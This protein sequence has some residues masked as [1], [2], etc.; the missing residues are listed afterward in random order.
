[1]TALAY[2]DALELLGYLPST[3][4]PIEILGHEDSV[5]GRRAYRDHCAETESILLNYV[6][7]DIERSGFF[8]ASYRDETPSV[9]DYIEERVCLVS[10]E[11]PSVWTRTWFQ[12]PDAAARALLR[13]RLDPQWLADARDDPAPTRV[14]R[15]W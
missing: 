11:K 3:R 6:R 14:E 4:H 12:T 10:I 5:E 1:M 13:L 15:S 8:P 7:R 9:G 2:A